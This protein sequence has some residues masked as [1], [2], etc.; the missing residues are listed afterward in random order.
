MF[1]LVPSQLMR[2]FY[3]EISFEFTDFQKATLIWNA[4][5]KTR[6]EI[7]DALRELA[8][9]TGDENTKKQIF[10]RIDFEERVFTTFIN[11][12]SSKYVYVVVDSEDDGSY[13]FF[14][15][16]NMAIE[17]ALKYAE[18]YE[19]KCSVRKQLIVTTEADKR[20]RNPW[21]GNPNM[22]IEVDEYN[23]YQGNAVAEVK[24]NVNGDIE[25]LWS[26]ELTREDE[27]IVDEY[28]TDRF[29][30]QFIK[31]PFDLQVGS[32]VKDVI[33]GTYG[34][35]AQ[36]KE[37]WDKYLQKIEDRKLYVDYSD[38]QVMVYRL[39]ENGYWSHEHI[40]PM[41]LDIE[42][43]PYIQDDEKRNALRH[44]ME[45]FG[46]YL[47]H[48]DRGIEFCPEYVLKY[49]KEYAMVCQEKNQW[50]R[51]VEKANIP[52]DIMW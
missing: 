5:E 36:G 22:G 41:H 21:K 18:K 50:D 42:I 31:V 28:R 8:E 51:I 20:V 52:E 4:P 46:D 6:R 2:D 11:N 19:T 24:L 49:A 16:Y 48:K 10:E 30:Y 17:Y 39:T 40:N 45:A 7:L 37:E 9:I 43:P 44:A 13:G 3:N 14:A 1:E 26:D 12:Q 38:V 33:S 25:C 35:L 23:E 27:F 32:P 47:S 29:E 34:I 15:D